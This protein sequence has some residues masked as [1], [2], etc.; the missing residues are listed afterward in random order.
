MAKAAIAGEA[1]G[2]MIEV[3]DDPGT[4]LCDGP[5]SITPEDYDILL[6][7]IKAIATALGKRIV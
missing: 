3:H 5:Q 4:A 1:D 6:I 7:Q 2:L